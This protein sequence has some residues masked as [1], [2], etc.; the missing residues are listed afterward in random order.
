LTSIPPS[1]RVPGPPKACGL[2]PPRSELRHGFRIPKF[3]SARPSKKTSPQGL[4]PHLRLL[5]YRP[6][7]SLRT[8]HSLFM[9]GPHARMVTHSPPVATP[10]FVPSQDLVG[11]LEPRPP[12][13][14]PIPAPWWPRPI[15]RA[16]LYTNVLNR[17]VPFAR[18][19]SLPN[20]PSPTPTLQPMDSHLT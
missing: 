17:P 9:P 13:E 15:W 16:N 7:T 2:P 4:E 1:A 10:S 20:N 18:T 3:L 14:L 5:G 11:F 6:R 8:S 19:P 12:L